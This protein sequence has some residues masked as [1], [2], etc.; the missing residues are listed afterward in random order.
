M[1]DIGRLA[2]VSASTVSRALNNSPAIPEATKQRIL[3]IA[4]D[5]NYQLNTQA[6]NFRLQR[7]KTIATVFPYSG[8]SDRLIS[9]PFYLEILAAITDEL[10]GYDYDLILSRVPSY[11]DA[12]C[13]QYVMNK[14]VDGFIFVDRA[15]DDTSLATLKKLNAN[16][17]VWGI[18]L[19]NQ[20][21]VSVGCNSFE[22]GRT[23]VRHLANLGRQKIA[24]I[25]GH[26]GMVATSL[27]HRGYQQGLADCGLPY[28]PELVRYTDFTPHVADVAIQAILQAEPDVDAVFLCSDFMAVAVMEVLRA[29][30][31]SVP[32]QVSVIGYDDIPLA[33]YCSPRLTT[34]RQDLHRGA[35]L[36][37]EKLFDMMDGKPVQSTMLPIELIVRDSCG[38]S[39]NHTR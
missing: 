7:S 4:T 35:A 19:E 39:P 38:A 16:Y 13:Q 29:N 2:G 23:A 21:Y 20:N 22:G 5:H 3:K 32:Q 34:I 11:D 17:V 27:R 28:R 8:D 30:G 9:D 15:L 6:Q 12:W 25:G 1:A 26:E 31:R 37:I 36:L 14:R 24:F 33:A 18:P 10:A